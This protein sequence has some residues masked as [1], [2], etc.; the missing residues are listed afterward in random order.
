MNAKIDKDVK[1]FLKEWIKDESF[2]QH[3]QSEVEKKLHKVLLDWA[4]T[5]KIAMN[6]APKKHTHRPLP[7]LITTD[8]KTR[9]TVCLDCGKKLPVKVK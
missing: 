6:F 1:K 3:I 8:N 7:L 4:R 9:K 5:G 2:Q